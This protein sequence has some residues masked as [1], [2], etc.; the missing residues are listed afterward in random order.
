[1]PLLVSPNA[2]TNNEAKV[3]NVSGTF[4]LHI[5]LGPL[6]PDQSTIAR[7]H[8]AC[9]ERT[10]AL[11]GADANVR[12]KDLV[13]TLLF[14]DEQH[15]E[16]KPVT[17]MQS[18]HYVAADSAH[19]AV[20]L[21]RADAAF[22]RA[23]GFEVLREKTEALASNK[24]VPETDGEA[25]ALHPACYFE[26]HIKLDRTFP[27][28]REDQVRLMELSMR[29]SKEH[30]VCVPISWNAKD[31]FQVF[32][33][34]RTYNRGRAS[35]TALCETIKRAAIADGFGIVKVIREYV[36]CTDDNTELDGGWLE[37]PFPAFHPL[38]NLN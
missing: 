33:N 23:K 8:D 10:A 2:D 28:Q 22:F 30:G 14:T 13:V 21:A 12:I 26:F 32:L 3:P 7:F 37:P 29:L 11:S 35:T 16:G 34:L 17:V 6:N 9:A 24:G 25:A 27:L 20:E 19:A 1:M 18:S 15:E 5:F 38:Q 4:E 36:G 31:P